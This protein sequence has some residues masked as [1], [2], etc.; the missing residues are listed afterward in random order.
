MA[1]MLEL[2]EM[3]TQIIGHAGRPGEAELVKEAARRARA[4]IPEINKKHQD[5][6]EVAWGIIA[7]AGGGD[8]KTQ[9]PEWV[10]AAEAW[11][12]KYIT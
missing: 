11:R 12:D 2:A 7:N 3:L 8:W 5:E 10:K 6:R 9:S 4:M 1:T